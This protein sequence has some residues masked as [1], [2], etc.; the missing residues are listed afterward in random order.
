MGGSCGT[1]GPHRRHTRRPAA[2]WPVRGSCVG[3]GCLILPGRSAALACGHVSAYSDRRD[4]HRPGGVPA[5]GP[6]VTDGACAPWWSCLRR[7]G[8]RR[9]R[10]PR[11]G[12][13]SSCGVETGLRAHA[14]GHRA[15]SHWLWRRRRATVPGS[16]GRQTRRGRRHVARRPVGGRLGCQPPRVGRGT[17]P[18]VRRIQPALAGAGD[19]GTGPPGV[20]LLDRAADVA[21]DRRAGAAV[22]RRL[23]AH[24]VAG[25]VDRQRLPGVGGPQSCRSCRGA[26]PAQVDARK[27]RIPPRHPRA[28]RP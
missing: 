25:A 26:G 1:P 5:F 12:P 21:P 19:S 17:H 14:G 18:L 13:A 8:A 6:R 23:P 7:G 16:A 24:H 27:P 15:D 3:R 2:V 11:S 20:Q 22:A 9:A 28:R 10:S 4:T